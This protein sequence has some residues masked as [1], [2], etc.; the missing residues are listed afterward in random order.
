MKSLISTQ[1]IND[2]NYYL[3]MSSDYLH[4]HVCIQCFDTDDLLNVTIC[5]EK[6]DIHQNCIK[7]YLINKSYCGVCH[8]SINDNVIINSRGCTNEWYGKLIN[9]FLIILFLSSFIASCVIFSHE[10]K[11][12]DPSYSFGLACSIISHVII[13]F[14]FLSTGILLCDPLNNGLIY[15]YDGYYYCCGCCFCCGLCCCNFNDCESKM[16]PFPSPFRLCKTSY[17]S[18]LWLNI[19]IGY[20]IVIFNTIANIVIVLMYYQ[21]NNKNMY[22]IYGGL[23]CIGLTPILSTMILYPL[24]MMIGLGIKNLICLCRK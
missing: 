13:I 12:P 10:F 9:R 22:I 24:I 16:C 11:Y 3:T 18:K 8:K 6:H 23:I 5:C 20:S 7:Y 19:M 1:S 2:L 4:K 21:N 14:I 17:Y 15:P